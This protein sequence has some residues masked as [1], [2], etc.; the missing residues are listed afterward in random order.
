[1]P[2]W[3][4]HAACRGVQEEGSRS[5]S[6][7]AGKSATYELWKGRAAVIL[8]L[9]SLLTLVSDLT[10]WICTACWG[11]YQRAACIVSSLLSQGSSDSE[12][13]A[14]GRR[15]EKMLDVKLSREISRQP[16]GFPCPSWAVQPPAALDIAFKFEDSAWETLQT[17]TS[18]ASG[19]HCFC[20]SF[21]PWL[22][23]VAMINLQN[24]ETTITVKK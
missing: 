5:P 23:I 22:L 14:T 20:V 1:M 9:P 16:S 6:I 4:L 2:H 10:V 21:Q 12:P 11:K 8:T 13:C 19:V 15:K 3:G 18:L 7:K 24:T 17:E